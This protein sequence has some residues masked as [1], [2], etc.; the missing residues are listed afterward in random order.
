MRRRI[1]SR[2]S[3]V[4]FGSGSSP[5]LPMSAESPDTALAPAIGAG[6]R[7]L[8]FRI[9]LAAAAGFT[10]GHLLGWDFPFLP[11]LIAVQLL[12]SG[13]SLDVKRAGGFVLLIAIGCGVRL[14]LFP[15]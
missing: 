10:L 11:S 12:A 5:C 8:A 4:H 9:A 13:A 6:E 14:F 3:L 2:T 1:R 15:F 7:A